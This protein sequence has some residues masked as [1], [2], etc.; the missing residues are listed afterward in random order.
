M[1][2][3]NVAGLQTAAITQTQPARVAHLEKRPVMKQ[4]RAGQQSLNLLPRENHRQRA[5]LRQTDAL[6][7]RPVPRTRHRVEELQTGKNWLPCP[8]REFFLS[9]RY[10]SQDRT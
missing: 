10:T 1:L 9:A 3:I 2:R 7:R 6:Q 5:G 4:L 8:G